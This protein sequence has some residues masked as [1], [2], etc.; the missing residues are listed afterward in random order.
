MILGVPT[1]LRDSVKD[2]ELA[3][4]HRRDASCR[5]IL[6]ARKKDVLDA[7]SLYSEA[8]GNP[9]L[10]SPL[11]ASVEEGTALRDNYRLTR[12]ASP[13]QGLRAEIFGLAPREVCLICGRGSVGSLDHH[14]P[15]SQYPEFSILALNL[16]P[17]CETCNEKKRNHI[18]TEA[19]GRF[20]HPYYDKIPESPPLLIATISI[21][22]AA[23]TVAVEFGIN[24]T[25]S[26][27]I[28]PH[29]MFHFKM[30]DL[31]R[32][33]M[34]AAIVELTDRAGTFTDL[35]TA[36]GA[37][38]ISYNATREAASMRRAWG[39]HY[40]KAALYSGLAAAPSFCDGGFTFLA[41]P[42]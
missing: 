4:T 30:L 42:D 2:F 8:K 22:A 9:S 6:Q 40:W 37:Q 20:L 38:A 3:A 39:P 10:V 34:R 13:L 33:Y 18:G 27:E 24:P 41:P 14:L 25:L 28:L 23:K 1:P 36:G 12:P 19:T 7:Y 5:Q 32:H 15:K 16:V 21:D 31:S 17:A 35:F 29:A 26:V 11:A